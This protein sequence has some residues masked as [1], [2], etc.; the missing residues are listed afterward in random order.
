MV[1][2]AQGPTRAIRFPAVE[3]LPRSL[4]FYLIFLLNYLGV[5]PG[6]IIGFHWSTART[7]QELSVF[8]AI[9]LPGGLHN[10]NNKTRK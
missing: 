8:L 1:T 10:T 7:S 9:I 4:Q 2:V 5:M 6:F 3:R